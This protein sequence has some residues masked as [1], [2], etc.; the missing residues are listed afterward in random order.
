MAYIS[1]SGIICDVH[2]DILRD[3]FCVF[4]NGGPNNFTGLIW[5]NGLFSN[6]VSDLSVADSGRQT[7]ASRVTALSIQQR[8]GAFEPTC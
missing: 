7:S 1:E 3:T 8:D 5:P 6:V 4:G 2:R